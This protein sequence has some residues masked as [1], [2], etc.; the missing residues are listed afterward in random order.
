MRPWRNITAAASDVKL[1]EH[2]KAA[3]AFAAEAA[4]LALAAGTR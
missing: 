3:R 2:L 1:D 4:G